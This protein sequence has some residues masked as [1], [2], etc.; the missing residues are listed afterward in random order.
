MNGLGD[1]TNEE[2]RRMLLALRSLDPNTPLC[3]LDWASIF[4]AARSNLPLE[5]GATIKE[6][7]VELDAAERLRYAGS[8]RALETKITDTLARCGKSITEED[9]E[10]IAPGERRRRIAAAQAEIAACLAAIH[11]RTA[12]LSETKDHREE[13]EDA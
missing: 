12:R 7:L 1:L 10:R 13:T 3:A 8:R 11:Q 5:A 6:L 2:R 4:A 9:W